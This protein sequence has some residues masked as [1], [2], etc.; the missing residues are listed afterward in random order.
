MA[1]SWATSE[2][3]NS[4]WSSV[5]TLSTPTTWSCQVSGTDSIEATNRRW[6][7]PRTHRKRWSA[8]TSGMTIGSRVAAT[9]PVIPSPNGTTARPMWYRSRPLVAASVSGVPSR[10]SR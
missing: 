3:A 8:A 6:S 1:E 5:W 9:R 7:M 10:S 2:P 4:R